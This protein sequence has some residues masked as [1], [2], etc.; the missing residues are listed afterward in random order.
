MA[1]VVDSC[2]LLDLALHDP[3]WGLSA[4][5]SLHQLAKDGLIVCPV[6]VVEIA[7]QFDGKAENVR[8]FLA[9]AGI[10]SVSSWIEADT[11]SAAEAWSRYVTARRHRG[12]KIPKRP[13]ADLLI[14]GF[15]ERHD[16]LVTR[17]PDDFT[18]WFPTLQLKVPD[19]LAG[20]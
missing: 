3:E 10:Q 12:G 6:S 13:V 7:P 5:Q 8:R 20:K 2:V 15:A 16:G 11:S 1:W 17:N 4:A 18:P 14:G 19:K 9:I